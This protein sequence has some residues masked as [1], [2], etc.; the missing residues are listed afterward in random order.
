MKLLKE[1]LKKKGIHK[2]LTLTGNNFA[3]L[4]AKHDITKLVLEKLGIKE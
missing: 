1:L 3:Y 4:D 2:F